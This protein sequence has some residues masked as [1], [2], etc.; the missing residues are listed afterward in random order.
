MATRLPKKLKGPFTAS[1][2]DRREGI[3]YLKRENGD[4]ASTRT[5]PS[6]FIEKSYRDKFPDDEF[7]KDIIQWIDEGKHWRALMDPSIRRDRIHE[8]VMI[9]EDEDVPILEADVSP[10]RRWFSDTGALVSQKFRS[11]FFDLETH[12][13]QI[14]FDDEAK[15]RHR[16]ISWAAYD[17]EGNSWFEAA[18][19][20]SDANE[21]VLIKKLL[22]VAR[23]YDVLL[24]WNGDDYDFFVLKQRC[25]YHGLRVDWRQW[26]LLDYMRV[27]KKLLMSISD[28]DLKRSFALDA[29]GENVLGIKKIK[30]P[31]GGGKMHTLLKDRVNILEEYNRRDVEI[32]LGVEE[33]REFLALHYALCSI[34]RTFPHRGSTF[35]NELADGMLLRMAVQEDR[36]FASRRYKEVNED[37]QK[38]EGAYVLDPIVGFHTDIQVPDFASLYPSIILSWNMSN[39]TMLYDGKDY[40]P[41]V[42]AD[43]AVATATGV[44]FRTDFEGMIPKALRILIEKRG[45][46]KKRSKDLDMASDEYKNV[47]RLS[48]AVKVVANSFYGLMGNEGSRYHNREIARSVTLTGQLLIR[49]MMRYFERKGYTSVAGDTD[50]VFVQTTVPEMSLMLRDINDNF[51]PGLLHRFGCKSHAVSMDFDKG[52]KTLLIVTK[53]RYAGKLGLHKGRDA[54]EDMKPEIKGLEIRRSDWARYT[55]DLQMKYIKLLLEEDV[56][57]SDID[58]ALREDGQIF[59]TKELSVEELVVNKGLS[60]RPEDYNPKPPH[61]RVAQWLIDEGREFFVGMKI[62]YIVMEHK[63]NVVA[64]HADEYQGN[65]DRAYYWEKQIL[66]S[67][68]RLVHA[69]FPGYMFSDFKEPRQQ[70]FDFSSGARR[71]TKKAKGGKKKKVMK[72]VKTTKKVKKVPK[73]TKKVKKVPKSEVVTLTIPGNVSPGVVKGIGK[74]CRAFPGRYNLRITVDLRNERPRAEVDISTEQFVSMDCLKE[75]AAAFPQV[76]I[77][78]KPI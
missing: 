9:C 17:Q 2:Y 55:Q 44:R 38:Y 34:C 53:K 28:P 20:S 61:V 73:A 54:P 59:F 42:M 23:D 56:D 30:L 39:E 32:M 14:G 1:F 49:E 70:Q 16:I 35:P 18:P 26:N 19:S 60:K 78:P 64:I 65:C 58:N 48:T 71:T 4:V 69:R 15:K 63:P 21:E 36:H 76:S 10:V 52:F 13:L 29:V 47:T 24:A 74:L 46:Y 66:P 12:P 41:D 3:I 77:E 11:L 22:T 37:Y 57:P 51:I 50:S 31:V 6:F 5:Y 43:H 7:A 68:L 40:P 33:K 67:I 25:K 27:V 8:L 62:P 72:Q 75:I 45:E